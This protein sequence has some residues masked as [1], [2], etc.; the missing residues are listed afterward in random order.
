MPDDEVIDI[1]DEAM[2]PL[3]S[4]QRGRA[5]REGLWH[6]TFHCWIWRQDASGGYLVFQQRGPDK[7]LFPNLLDVSAAGHLAAGES[8]ADG[9]RE[10]AEELGLVVP[11]SALQPLGVERSAGRFGGL[12]DRE[13]CHLFL[14]RHDVP[15]DSYRP[16]IDEVPALVQILLH[17]VA[18]LLDG[19]AATVAASGF[20]WDEGASPRPIVRQVAAS[21]ITPRPD[22]YYPRL[23]AQ[24]RAVRGL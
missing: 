16:R 4:A 18:R 20:A 5:H 6:Q 1:F 2:H 8:V 19:Q 22:G 17:D 11:F 9:V 7:D 12:I 21:D 15:L 10:V 23:F 14:L 24:L 13:F 3:G